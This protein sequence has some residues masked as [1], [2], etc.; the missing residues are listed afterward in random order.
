MSKQKDASTCDDRQVKKEVK[1]LTKNKEGETRRMNSKSINH[2]KMAALIVVGLMAVVGMF[3]EDAA[4]ALDHGSI[5]GPTPSS[6]KEQTIL[7]T[8]QINYTFDSAS[9]LS[10]ATTG[11]SGDSTAITVTL[12]EGWSLPNAVDPAVVIQAPTDA[13]KAYITVNMLR[14]NI[15][16]ASGTDLSGDIANLT[17]TSGVAYNSSSRALTITLSHSDAASD[18]AAYRASLAGRLARQSIAV[19]FHKVKTAA[20]GDGSTLVT[21]QQTLNLTVSDGA[22]PAE[23]AGIIVR[24]LSQS[25]VSLNSEASAVK[26]GA[27]VSKVEVTYKYR[28]TM[29]SGNVITLGLPTNWAAA[30]AP[31]SGNLTDTAG[32]GTLQ[33]TTPTITGDQPSKRS[34]VMVTATGGLERTDN[35]VE[36]KTTYDSTLSETTV[37]TEV[38]AGGDAVPSEVGNGTKITVSF[39]NVRVPLTLPGNNKAAFNVSDAFKDDPYTYTLSASVSNPA[40]ATVT[41]TVSNPVISST[42]DVK[43]TYVVT[44]PLYDETEV[45]IGLPGGWDAAFPPASNPGST[46][47]GFGAAVNPS[48]AN[49]AK[50][51]YVEVT[52]RLDGGPPISEDTVNTDP[53]LVSSGNTRVRIEAGTVKIPVL[54]DNQT[55][56]MKEGDKITAVFRNVMLQDR[57]GAA[58]FTISDKLEAGGD[59]ADETRS[60]YEVTL[61]VLPPTLS[62][63]RVTPHSVKERSTRDITVTYQVRHPS[64][65]TDNTVTI[66]LPSGL[67]ALTSL[68]TTFRDIPRGVTTLPASLDTGKTEADYQYVTV[69]DTVA[70]AFSASPALIGT[71]VTFTGDM[72]LNEEITV[73]YHNV[74]INPLPSP[75]APRKDIRDDLRQHIQ[76][77]DSAISH[78]GS[79]YQMA[80]YQPKIRITTTA[81]NLS[82]VS[83]TPDPVKGEEVRNMVVAYTARDVVYDNTINIALPSGWGPKYGSSFSTTAAANTSYVTVMVT[84]ATLLVE[85][86]LTPSG[87]TGALELSFKD[88]MSMP[89]GSKITVTYHNVQVPELELANRPPP[90]ANIVKAQFTVTDNITGSGGYKAIMVNKKPVNKTQVTVAHPNLSDIQVT[91]Q[92]V[93]EGSR[94]PKMT[95]TYTA[96]DI[97]Y[98]GNR[99]DIRI[100]AGWDPVYSDFVNETSLLPTDNKSMTSYVRITPRPANMDLTINSI[101]S[102]GIDMQVNG[103]MGNG[104]RITVAFFNVRVESLTNRTPKEAAIR[105][106]D[107]LSADG[108]ANAAHSDL[109]IEVNP[110]ELSTVTVMP[111]QAQSSSIAGNVKVT[112]VVTDP[113]TA[114]NTITIGLPNALDTW[115]AAYANDGDPNGTAGFGS[116]F[117]KSIDLAAAAAST[118]TTKG[119]VSTKPA[120]LATGASASKTS[121][122]TA[123]YFPMGTG[124]KNTAAVSISGNSITVAVTGP[125]TADDP[126]ANDML[127]RDR[128]VVT[129]YNVKVPALE[130]RD[131]VGASI[132]VSDALTSGETDQYA[133]YDGMAQIRVNPPPRNMVSVKPAEVEAETVT[134]V[135]VTYSITAAVY[136]ANTITVGLPAGWSPAYRPAAGSSLSKSFGPLVNPSSPSSR[137][138]YVKVSSTLKATEYKVQ[139]ITNE[140]SNASLVIEVNEP[141][142]SFKG[143]NITVTFH[144]VK[145]QGLTAAPSATDPSEVVKLTMTDNIFAY[146][147]IAGSGRDYAMDDGESKASAIIKVI[148]LK[149]GA[150]A[151]SGLPGTL[152]AEDILDPLRIR[153]TATDDLADPD[154]DR[155]ADTGD[156]TYGRIQVT[157][158]DGWAP[159]GGLTQANVEVTGSRGVQLLDVDND[160]ETSEHDVVGQTITV[161]VDSLKRGEYVNITIPRLRVA[162]F[163]DITG[164]THDVVVRV[165]SDSFDDNSDR[166]GE[167]DVYTAHTLSKIS[168]HIIDVNVSKDHPTIEVN[169]RYLGEVTV[170]PA[171]VTAEQ[172]ANLT[173]RYTATKD[174]ADPNPDR[175]AD[176][177]DATY[178]RIQITLPDGWGPATAEEIYDKR[179][180]NDREATYWSL[181]S[182]FGR[183]IQ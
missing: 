26:R 155:N 164:D 111:A 176:T 37:R 126:T 9:A 156:A 115:E 14:Q 15:P 132:R 86:S 165:F 149:R 31:H 117:D 150:V 8:L 97:I 179:Q 116:S 108:T 151:I 28:D 183:H 134:D 47:K 81:T 140:T 98:S 75:T 53:R 51:S 173:I 29:V 142:A 57:T 76:V 152:Y 27:V 25:D 87:D 85:D 82:D 43:V 55:E 19:T 91:P 34:Y 96:K 122:V 45:S 62:D 65:V 174:L 105:V 11:L 44:D 80:S 139:S 131:S 167:L 127:A 20:L 177:D 95:V 46:L 68:E 89:N 119:M 104:N 58:E 146:S 101:T 1:P 125:V 13:N 145:V 67:T 178:G 130:D 124:R 21:D 59:A 83:V 66:D 162:D 129:Y 114:D 171:K 166:S 163:P 54:A 39:H 4:S 71:E 168:P 181:R 113:I 128:I 77:T 64:G 6:V 154:P 109:K 22:T 36:G 30:Y 32:F 56:A 92:T 136:E 33:Y 157:L 110:P 41:P 135:M 100:P 107:K 159:M 79:A 120:T 137:T 48:G 73:I 52:V 99:I 61:T 5:S 72:A 144:N 170:T 84:P 148:P 172:K 69:T 24:A 147:T 143:K 112:Y 180:P 50:S 70:A 78:D 182:I 42:R 60:N 93:K 90:D 121:Y 88:G 17:L 141:T 138:S 40:L 94:V 63:I 153:Y 18:A 38:R 102:D 106:T 12:P 123:Q 23:P 160:P 7:D 35:A 103:D 3:A 2:W 175:D 161:D 118:T 49:R 10:N 16:A 133:P 158:P 74:K 169:R